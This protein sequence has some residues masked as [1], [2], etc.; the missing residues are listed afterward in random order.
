M[1]LRI[2]KTSIRRYIAYFIDLFVSSIPLLLIMMVVGLLNKELFQSDLFSIPMMIGSMAILYIIYE[3]VF[4]VKKQETIGR[5]VTKLSVSFEE[6]NVVQY[7]IRAVVKVI[8]L[9]LIAPVVLSFI[10]MNYGDA[11]SSLHDKIAK[12]KVVFR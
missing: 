10:M 4:F 3:I 12:S 8:S 2:R 1:R 9:V 7:S 11:T 6:D 5:R